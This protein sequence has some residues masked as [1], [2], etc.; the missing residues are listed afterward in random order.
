[1]RRLV[2]CHADQN[3]GKEPPDF[4]SKVM[5]KERKKN[6]KKSYESERKTEESDGNGK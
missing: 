6:T 1:M 5:E 4:I 2:Q 3:D